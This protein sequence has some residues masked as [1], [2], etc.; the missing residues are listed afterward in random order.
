MVADIFRDATVGQLFNYFSNGTILPYPEERSDFT[1]P[2]RFLPSQT[3]TIIADESDDVQKPEPESQKSKEEV[4]VT[5]T[6]TSREIT[7]DENEGLGDL[8]A[9]KINDDPYLVTWYGVDDP[10]NPKFV[11]SSS[12]LITA[13]NN[14]THRNWSSKKRAFVGFCVTWMTFTSYVG[15]AIYIA[16]IPGI[17][18]QFHVGLTYAELGLTLYVFGLSFFLLPGI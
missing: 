2:A 18:E 11:F 15:S 1:V 14:Y 17:M 10:E 6:E 5:E 16:A 13:S 7:L 8:E 9:Q 4:L 3:P 12:T